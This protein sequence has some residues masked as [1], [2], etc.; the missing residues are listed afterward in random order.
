MDAMVVREMVKQSDNIIS[1]HL[2]SLAMKNQE[3]ARITHSDVQI[4]RIS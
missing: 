3:L 2:F 4:N 1:P